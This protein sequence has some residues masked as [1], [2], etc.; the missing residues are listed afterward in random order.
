MNRSHLADCITNDLV[1]MDISVAGWIEDV[2]D[3]GKLGFV[4]MR[5][6]TGMMQIIVDGDLLSQ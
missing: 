2:R 5:D 6:F 3:I 4:S 1:D